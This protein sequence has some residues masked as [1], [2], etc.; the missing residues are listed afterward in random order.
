MSELKDINELTQQDK[1]DLFQSYIELID[2]PNNESIKY[3]KNEFYK[4]IIHCEILYMPYWLV[5]ELYIKGFNVL[6]LDE[7]IN[8]KK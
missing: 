4:N 1:D 8:D 3:F 5:M 2:P 6:D 7:Y